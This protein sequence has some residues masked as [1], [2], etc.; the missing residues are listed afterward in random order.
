MIC[1]K[2][3]ERARLSGSGDRNAAGGLLAE[4]GLH[5][6]IHREAWRLN[7]RWHG[8]RPVVRSCSAGAR[9]RRDG[10]QSG[11]DRN[12]RVGTIGREFRGPNCLC[13]NRT[14]PLGD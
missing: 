1:E 10:V 13:K 7:G 3:G 8:A 9:P 12:A 11:R 4:V 14:H 5:S 6:V 2:C